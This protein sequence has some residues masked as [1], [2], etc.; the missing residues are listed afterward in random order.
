MAVFVW[1]SW[2]C[3]FL[4]VCSFV[5]DSPLMF[6]FNLFNLIGKSVD[7]MGS[8]HKVLQLLWQIV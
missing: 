2:G 1:F 7:V 5:F 8:F 3:F 6:Y 4:F